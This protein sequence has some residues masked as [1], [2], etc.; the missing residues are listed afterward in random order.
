MD[1]CSFRTGYQLNVPLGDLKFS[2]LIIFF[3]YP[4]KSESYIKISLKTN[5]IIFDF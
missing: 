5:F 2:Q 4:K 1:Y 3:W